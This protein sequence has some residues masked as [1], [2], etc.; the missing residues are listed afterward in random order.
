MSQP[1]PPNAPR[2]SRGAMAM[3]DQDPRSINPSVRRAEPMNLTNRATLAMLIQ[4]NGEDITDLIRPMLMRYVGDQAL[5]E[6]EMALC[7]YLN[8][9]VVAREDEGFDQRREM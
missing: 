9:C 3:A 5:T 1:L 6:A 4:E 7:Q 2:I 8:D